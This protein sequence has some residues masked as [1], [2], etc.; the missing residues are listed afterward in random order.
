MKEFLMREITAGE[1]RMTVTRTRTSGGYAAIIIKA[2]DIS[3][4]FN[5]DKDNN[6]EEQSRALAQL[7]NEAVNNPCKLPSS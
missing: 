6:Y 4:T 5:N 3:I 2:G 1:G 7:I